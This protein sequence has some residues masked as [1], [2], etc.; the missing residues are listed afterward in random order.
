MVS[1][2]PH[3]MASKSAVAHAVSGIH[4]RS[5]IQPRLL[6]HLARAPLRVSCS[7]GISAL[8]AAC[9]ASHEDV[10]R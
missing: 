6:R 9:Y 10:P 8:S 2:I 5:V 4:G 3:A 7:K 1:A